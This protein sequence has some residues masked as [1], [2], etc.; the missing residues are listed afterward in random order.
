MRRMPRTEENDGS[1]SICT[2]PCFA[3]IFYHWHGDDT[4]S[5]VMHAVRSIIDS[6]AMPESD[7]T[8]LKGEMAARFIALSRG[9]LMPIKHVVGPMDTVKGIEIYEVR[10]GVE[11][12]ESDTAQVRVYHVEPVDMQHDDGSGSVVVGVGAHH[13]AIIPGV[14][15]NID[16]DAELQKARKRYFDGKPGNWGGASLV[17][18]L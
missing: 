13:K 6:I 18:L 11:F 4:H 3:T 10:G 16:Q 1:T 15:P 2:K 9:E 17:R 14:D 12:G 8:R 7:K 5:K